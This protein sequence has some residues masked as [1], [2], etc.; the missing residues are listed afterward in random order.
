MTKK[1]LIGTVAQST[2]LSKKDVETVFKSIFE[3]IK[4]SLSEGGEGAR[5]AIKGFGTFSVKRR[6]ARTGRHPAT[7]ELLEIPERTVPFFSAGTELKAA[8]AEAGEP[9]KKKKKATTKK[10]TTTTKKKTTT[11]KKKTT[12]KK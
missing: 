4:N 5:I 3:T 12:K 7:K 11:T 1:E 9:K 10:K 6:A 8:V 2:G